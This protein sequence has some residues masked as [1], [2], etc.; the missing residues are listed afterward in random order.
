MTTKN[1]DDTLEKELTKLSRNNFRTTANKKDAIMQA[2]V[3]LFLK[4]GYCNTTLRQIAT[5]T[6]TSPSLIIY[7]FGAKEGIAQAYLRSKLQELYKALIPLIDIRTEPELFCCTTVR[8]FQTI[9]CS[10]DICYFYHDMIEE[11]LFREFFFSNNESV[12]SAVLILN[13]RQVKLNPDL[14]LFYGH[15]I[16]PSIELS[17]WIHA[18]DGIPDE[19][20]LDIP[21]RTFMGL[22]YVPKEEVDEY[23]IK[24]KE[25]VTQILKQKPEL[26]EFQ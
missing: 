17:L 4:Q 15:Y 26:L 7:H 22:I 19:S 14:L 5:A 21:F 20:M 16:I 12:N 6:N 25:L 18:G 10:P 8:L 24:A 23:C 1:N 9:M 3:K 13:K 11:G 2:A